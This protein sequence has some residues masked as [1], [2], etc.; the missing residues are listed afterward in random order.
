[1][2]VH[3]FCACVYKEN[4]TTTMGEM[5]AVWAREA[6]EV[7]PQKEG[8][9]GTGCGQFYPSPNPSTPDGVCLPHTRYQ[10]RKPCVTTSVPNTLMSPG[11]C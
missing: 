2:C 3:I 8:A 9:E 4:P 6:L 1:M 11:T 5:P 7:S 10:T